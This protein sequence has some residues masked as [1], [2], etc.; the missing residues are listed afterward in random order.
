MP[1]DEHGPLP[2]LDGALP[3]S[4]HR[5][6]VLVPPDPPRVLAGAEWPDGLIVVERGVL[7]VTTPDGAT[8]RFDRG[9]VLAFA[10]TRAATIRGGDGEAA[11]LVV[12][13]RWPVQRVTDTA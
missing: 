3:G 9:S 6:E 11:V 7:E 4:F 10:R 5:E 1:G 8:A 12:I 13:R 2:L